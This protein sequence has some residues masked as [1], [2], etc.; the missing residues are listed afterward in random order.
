MNALHIALKDLLLFAKDRGQIVQLFLVP[1]GF[2]MA[3]SAAFGA[4]QKLQEQV[5]TVPLVNLDPGGET[6]EQL[7]EDLNAGRGIRTEPH[8]A[9][10][11]EADL[12][13]GTIQLALTIPADF[14]ADVKAGTPSSLRLAYGPAASLSQVEAVRLVAKGVAAQLSLETQLVNGLSQMAAMTS[15]APEEYQVFT[16]ERIR[17]QAASQIERAETQPLL[18]LTA[19]WPDQITR[20]RENFEPSTFGAAGFAIMFAFIAAQVTAT[21]IFEERKE[22]TFRRLLVSPMDRWELLIGKMLPNFLIAILQMVVVVAA[23]IVLLP[24][25]GQTAPTLGS[26]PLALAL[27]TILVALCS[28]SL[29]VLLGALCRTEAQVGGVSSAV[30]WVAGMVG[31]AFIPS[32]VL[33]DF[34]NTIGKAVPHYWALQAFNAVTLRGLG[35]IDILPQLGMLAAFTAVFFTAGLLKFKFE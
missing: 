17:E 9:A 23:S 27:I 12:A 34:L 19:K 26:A 30:L 15:D 21:S 28:T 8:D 25:I 32:F 31:G 5:L 24:A 13:G 11:V 10:T 16:A 6:S 35:M 22:G 4:S 3:F 2:I 7:V 33:G 20:G 29:G 1:I 18:A 14:S